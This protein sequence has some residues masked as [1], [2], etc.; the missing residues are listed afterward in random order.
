[1][2]I[3]DTLSRAYLTESPTRSDRELSDDI[4]ATVHTVP[5]E[6]SISNKTLEDV[7]NA[8]SSDAT[9]TELRALIAYGFPSDTSSLSSEL[10][11]YQKLVADMHEVDGLLVHNNKVILLLSL[12]LKMLNII[13]ENHSGIEKCKSLARQSLYWPSLTRDIEE[14]IG[15]FSIC[16]SY[17]RKQQQE[18]LPPHPVP[19]HPWQKLGADIFSFI[20]KDSLLIVDYYSEY[21][22]IS[23]QHDKTASSVITS[24]KSVFARHGVPDEI[25]ANNMPF[26]S[27][28]MAKFAKD[29]N[30][31]IITSSPHYA[32]FNGQAERTIQTVKSLLKKAMDS[33][34]NPYM[35]LLQ[36]RNPQ[37]SDFNKSL[38]E[39]LF[40]RP[41]KLNCR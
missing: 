36:Y 32:Q 25:M 10:K 27:K 14:L 41:L 21:P 17:H 3:A 20:N 40:N 7:R 13:H 5:H 31:N 16:H 30:F 34:C 39:L 24:M 26:S 22:E 4:E 9:L 33:D 2:Y 12:R 29:W 19:H 18:P 1:M 8:I 6:T 28:D 15:K 11:A 37:L 23:M 38:A 35:P